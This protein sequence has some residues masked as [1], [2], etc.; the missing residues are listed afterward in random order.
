MTEKILNSAPKMPPRDPRQP[1][2][3][4]P[5]P[6]ARHL[7]RTAR[8]GALG[9]LDP[10]SGAPFVTLTSVATDFDGTPV[11]LVSRLST[12]TQNLLQDQ[13]A[14]LMLAQ[15]GKGDPLAH[16]RL[17]LQVQAEI[18]GPL[19][20]PRLRERYL[21]RHPKAKLYADFPDF[22][23]FRLMPSA[24][25]L[26]GGFARAFDGDAQLVLNPLEDPAAF[27]EFETSALDHLNGEHKDALVLYATRFCGAPEAAWRASGLD[28][29]GLDLQAGDLVARLTF[30]QPVHSGGQLR[31]LLKSLATTA[32]NS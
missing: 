15:V 13:R 6:V 31:E 17:T 32:R 16:P 21:R 14:S 5:I 26:N 29:L 19:D 11:I 20:L 1:A 4:E 23:F 22:A 18:A 25:H 12:H 7:L 3:F 30:D 10:Q 2:D 9:T 24:V 27:Q 8:S 28:P